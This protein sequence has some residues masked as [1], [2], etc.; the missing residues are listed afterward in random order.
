MMH[1]KRT[2]PEGKEEALPYNRMQKIWSEQA[3]V[4]LRSGLLS[5]IR[6]RR[7]RRDFGGTD[8][9]ALLW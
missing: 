6:E 9:L 1:P 5:T 8:V 2:D 3:M 4:L 7:W